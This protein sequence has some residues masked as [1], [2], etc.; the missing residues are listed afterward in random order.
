MDI[1]TAASNPEIEYEQKSDA[2]LCQIASSTS[3]ISTRCL[4]FTGVESFADLVETS[5]RK[6]SQITS[7]VPFQTLRC[8]T[9]QA[10]DKCTSVLWQD[11]RKHG[12]EFTNGTSRQDTTGG[13]SEYSCGWLGWINQPFDSW[14]SPFK[15]FQTTSIPCSLQ[16]PRFDFMAPEA[17]HDLIPARF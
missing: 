5:T 16:P 8:C 9:L 13:S 15:G 7:L 12:S 3:M 1:A 6:L 11:K 17:H 10:V 14:C 4:T 2:V